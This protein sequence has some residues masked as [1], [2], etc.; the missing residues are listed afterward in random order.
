VRFASD[1]FAGIFFLSYS[2]QSSSPYILHDGKSI[3]DIYFDMHIQLQ[4]KVSFP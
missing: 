2:K 1:P 4:N 3:Q